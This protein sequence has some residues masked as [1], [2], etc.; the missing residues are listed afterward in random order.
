M[1]VSSCI[2]AV[3][4]EHTLKGRKQQKQLLGLISADEMTVFHFELEVPWQNNHIM[5]VVCC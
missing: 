5:L 1:Q 3:N 2:C 4:C